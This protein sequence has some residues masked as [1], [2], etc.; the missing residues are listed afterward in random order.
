MSATEIRALAAG[1]VTLDRFGDAML[2]GGSAFYAARTWRHLGAISGLATAFGPDFD[3]EGELEGLAVFARRGPNTTIF[4]NRYPAG[5][6]RE[7]T[8][9]AVAPPVEATLLPGAWHRPD[10]ALIAPVLG[11]IDLREWMDA[12]AA[13]VIGV[14]L[15]G[16]LKRPDPAPRGSARRVV[17][18]PS[19]PDLSPLAAARAVFLSD[20]DVLLLSDPSLIGRLRRLVSIVVLTRG[21]EGARVWEGRASFDVGVLPVPVVDPTGAGDTF[22]ATFLLALGRGESPRDAARLATAAAA[23]VVQGQGGTTLERVGEAILWR[24]RVPVD[25]P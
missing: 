1:H 8:V 4:T 25:P 10:V 18:R 12:L 15:Q 14:G 23:I 22:A 13:R 17:R 11:E 21:A 16:F 5:A 3:R 2:T 9:E 24:D 20:E 6:S 19:E 7:Q